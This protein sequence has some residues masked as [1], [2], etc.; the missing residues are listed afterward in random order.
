MINAIHLYK[1]ANTLYK[2]KIPILPKLIQTLMFLLYNSYIPYQTKIGAKTS[3]AYSGI[4]I[5]IHPETV[6]GKNV[7]IGTNVT[8]G[9]RSGKI[10]VPIIGNNVYLSTGAKILGAITIGDNA[11]VGANAVVIKDVPPYAVVAGVP[12]QIKKYVNKE[13]TTAYTRS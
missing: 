9:G 11:I 1:F 13:E 6:I 7:L 12:A 3:F 2:W 4:G 5:V 8:I 10:K